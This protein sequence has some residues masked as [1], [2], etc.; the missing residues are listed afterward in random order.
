MA[1]Y[2]LLVHI[3][4]PGTIP[5]IL[6]SMQFPHFC[7]KTSIKRS[8]S[9]KDKNKS[10]P[11]S[12][13]HPPSK[14]SFWNKY[15]SA[16]LIFHTYL[17]SFCCASEGQLL[18]AIYTSNSLMC[19]NL[20]EVF[21]FL[22]VVYSIQFFFLYSWAISSKIKESHSKLFCFLMT[23]AF[24]WIHFWSHHPTWPAAKWK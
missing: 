18:M 10:V 12:C 5:Q 4:L 16:F 11:F 22:I 24:L 17:I 7:L 6:G 2:A 21:F 8:T 14:V 19:L 1:I 15:P 23:Q 9:V 20:P 3:Q 13:S